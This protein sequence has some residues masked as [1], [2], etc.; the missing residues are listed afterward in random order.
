M[1]AEYDFPQRCPGAPLFGGGQPLH[2]KY[3][4]PSKVNFSRT[5]G[6]IRES[7]L[8]VAFKQSFRLAKTR[9]GK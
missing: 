3:A 1:S 6:A 7:K 2:W 8:L 9:S 5:A 4:L